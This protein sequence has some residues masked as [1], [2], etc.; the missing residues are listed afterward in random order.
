MAND[1]ESQF[2]NELFSQFS[3]KQD[4]KKSAL[5]PKEQYETLIGEIIEAKNAPKKSRNQ[6][7]LVKKYDKKYEILTCGDVQKN[8]SKTVRTH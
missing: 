2:T 6:L 4:A 5:I 1:I 3:S 8:H 7:Y